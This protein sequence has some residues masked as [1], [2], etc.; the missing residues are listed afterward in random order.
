MY[1]LRNKTACKIYLQDLCKEKDFEMSIHELLDYKIV[2]GYIYRSPDGDFHILSKNL[3]IVIQER[4]R[5]IL[6]GD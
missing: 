2:L 6:C 4:K 3:E 1:K 5:A